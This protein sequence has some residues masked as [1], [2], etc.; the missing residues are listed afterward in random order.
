MNII[1]ILGKIKEP[2]RTGI[3]FLLLTLMQLS[4][5]PGSTS[6]V[7]LM[8]FVLQNFIHSI[9][10]QAFAAIV[11]GGT[12]Y[13]V[14]NRYLKVCLDKK[15]ASST[16][17]KVAKKESQSHPWKLNLAFRLMYIPITIKN[18]F[19]SLSLTPFKIFMI[20]LTPEIL[21]FGSIYT[22]VG[23]KL[24]NVHQFFSSSQFK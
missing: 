15:F 8:S 12:T 18:V 5:I 14:S 16:L 21:I 11:S 23:I 19:L 3:F 6:L 13:F 22:M 7:I 1:L 4:F 17:Y 24:K 10:I 20:C 9:L 2:L